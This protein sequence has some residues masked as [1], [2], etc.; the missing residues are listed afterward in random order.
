VVGNG[1]S[2]SGTPSPKWRIPNDPV[3]PK[4]DES[5]TG[6]PGSNPRPPSAPEKTAPDNHESDN[7]RPIGK[8]ADG[9]DITEQGLCSDLPSDHAKAKKGAPRQGGSAQNANREWGPPDLS[10]LVG[11]VETMIVHL[12]AFHARAARLSIPTTRAVRSATTSPI[13]Y[14][15]GLKVG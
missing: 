4:H 8:R 7:G 1:V 9:V 3:D 6:Y 13:G 14:S 12:Q 5:Q 10:Y 2:R 15:D 11:V